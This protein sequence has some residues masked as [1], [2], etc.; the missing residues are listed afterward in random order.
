MT[1]SDFVPSISSIHLHLLILALPPAKVKPRVEFPE[2]IPTRPAQNLLTV[3]APEG[4]VLEAS[5]RDW[6]SIT[7]GSTLAYKGECS[8]TDTDSDTGKLLFI[9]NYFGHT[10]EYVEL[11]IPSEMSSLGCIRIV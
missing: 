11:L 7:Y 6:I 9:M 3:P 4:I 8:W 10:G 5:R 2:F 1:N